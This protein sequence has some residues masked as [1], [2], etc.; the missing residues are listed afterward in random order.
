M[1]MRT[2]YGRLAAAAATLVASALV[3]MAPVHTA[4][5]AGKSLSVDLGV[6]RGPST[7]VGEGFLYGVSQD[8]T[9]PVDQ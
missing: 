4:S 7:G 6:S 9:Q 1:R 2:R 8:G 5:A 3:L